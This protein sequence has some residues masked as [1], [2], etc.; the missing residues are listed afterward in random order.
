VTPIADQIRDGDASWPR[1]ASCR[2]RRAAR[3]PRWCARKRRGR[4]SSSTRAPSNVGATANAFHEL[5]VTDL[6]PGA[7]EHI[8]A[9]LTVLYVIPPQAPLTAEQYDGLMRASYA[10]VPSGADRED[11]GELPLHHDRPVR[12]LHERSE[13]LPRGLTRSHV[14][15]PSS[16][17]SQG[18]RERRAGIQ[19]PLK[20]GASALDPG[21]LCV[22]E[23]CELAFLE[24][25]KHFAHPARRRQ[26]TDG[27]DVQRRD[28]IR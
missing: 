16:R 23:A 27:G 10:S 19:R 21:S 20:L 4:R 26:S 22:R 3:S 6:R 9:P 8:R 14:S 28:R 17:A 15:R 11:R 2:I 18:A 1:R 7:G 13:H 5:I 24:A 12:S 25:S